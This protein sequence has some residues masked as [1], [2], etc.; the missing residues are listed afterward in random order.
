MRL[1]TL[2]SLF[3]LSACASNLHIDTNS[4][5]PNV[6]IAEKAEIVNQVKHIAIASVNFNT[7][8]PSYI[9]PVEG[10][11]D[12]AIADYLRQQGYTVLSGNIFESLWAKAIDQHGAYYHK[13]SA[14]FRRDRFTVI[15]DEVAQTLK[16]QYQVDAV[17]FTDLLVRKISYDARSPHYGR[18]DGVKFKPQLKGGDGVPSDFNWSKTFRALS[19]HVNLYDIEGD[20]LFQGLSGIEP[21][22]VMNVNTGN[23]KAQRRKKL[24]TSDTN[25]ERS[26]KLALHPF[27]TMPNH[28]A[29]Q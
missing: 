6:L 1:L 7:P 16:N 8:S 2:F 22:D 23:P 10:R 27:V 21:I 15:F 24:L 3:L 29:N 26:I 17:L 25:M 28:P 18:W 19:L 13:N 20:M 5:P 14:T 12:R 9:T 4:M 11:A